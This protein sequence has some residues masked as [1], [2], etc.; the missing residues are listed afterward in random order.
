MEH[1]LT[2]VSDTQ[3]PYHLKQCIAGVCAFL[4]DYRPNV[5]IFNGD[6]VD[7]ATISKYNKSKRLTPQ[8]VATEV[9]LTLTEVIFP[10]LEA[11]GWEIHWHAETHKAVEYG[12]EIARVRLDKVVRGRARVVWTQGNHEF[13]LERFIYAYAP[14]FE[15]LVEFEEIFLLKEL[16]IE[17]VRGRG[18]S[19]NGLI[20][21]N[22]NLAVC[23]G[24]R[25]GQYPARPTML[26]WGGSIVVGH[27]HKEDTARRTFASGLD[28]VAMAAGCLCQ[29]G[30]WKAFSGYNRG[31]IAGWYDDETDEFHLDHMRF[32]GDNWTKLYTPYGRYICL[33]NDK[34][35]WSS[36]RLVAPDRRRGL[37][38]QEADGGVGPAAAGDRKAKAK[39]RDGKR[40]AARRGKKGR[41]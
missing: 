12:L 41:D 27:A 36:R 31:F 15:G 13:R 5:H 26:D 19:G 24:E 16:G 17:Y 7:F 11:L 3:A 20:R 8:V 21:L 28:W 37:P 2:I 25:H 10:Q 6:M 32:S 9:F 35:G 29:D 22:R 39:Q 18:T 38:E 34:E 4:R 23:H 33:G 30:E 1:A 40:P 14:A